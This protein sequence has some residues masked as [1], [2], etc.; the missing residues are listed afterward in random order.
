MSSVTI[1]KTN[2]AHMASLHLCVKTKNYKN[3]SRT[4]K[5]ASRK[6]NC[7]KEVSLTMRSK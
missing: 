6:I 4:I 3:D 1:F 7:T 5:A 2:L